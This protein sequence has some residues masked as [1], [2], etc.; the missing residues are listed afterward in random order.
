MGF[1]YRLLRWYD[2][3]QFA[4]WAGS[5]LTAFAA[6]LIGYGIYLLPFI[7]KNRDI[8]ADDPELVAERPIPDP[9]SFLTSGNYGLT[10]MLL[11]WV[12]VIGIILIILCLILRIGKLILG[13]RG[14][15]S[16]KEGSKLDDKTTED[17]EN[18]PS[19][20]ADGMVPDDLYEEDDDELDDYGAEE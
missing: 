11:R 9:L 12:L 13:T 18:E 2:R 17:D 14:N 19:E 5:T 1:F 6:P 20:D 3:F 10:A 16:S 8:A 7:K 15:T 4:C